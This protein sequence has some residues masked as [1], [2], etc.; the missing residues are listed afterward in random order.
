MKPEW[1]NH[2]EK[3]ETYQ[4]TNS[5]LIRTFNNPNH[6]TDAVP[7]LATP[8]SVPIKLSSDAL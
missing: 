2:I 6:E 1:I 7:P 5:K 8:V 3:I 4:R